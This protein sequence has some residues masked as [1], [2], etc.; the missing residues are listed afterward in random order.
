MEE[1][2]IA[3][4][5][6][7]VNP[8]IVLQRVGQSFDEGFL[9]IVDDRENAS[10]ATGNMQYVRVHIDKLNH[11]LVEE[12]RRRRLVQNE[13]SE[14]Q[15]WCLVEAATA[16]LYMAYLASAVSGARPG[17]FPVTDHLDSLESL[18]G[19]GDTSYG[20][21]VD[22][23]R[24]AA[25]RQAL[26][27]PSG[28]VPPQEIIRFKE[29]YSEQLQRCRT[30]LDGTLADL[31]LIGDRRIQADKGYLVL[32]EIQDD[33]ARLRE[34]MIRRRWPQV[35]MAGVC[36][37]GAA[38]IASAQ[39]FVAGGTP[40]TV[41]LAVGAGLLGLGPATNDAVT[42]FREGRF[43]GNAPLAYAALAARQFG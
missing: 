43:D 13:V 30:Y 8:Q 25:I 9:Q 11:R 4:L 6:D 34:S 17:T 40:L 22:Q 14:R 42:R 32:Q 7:L 38:T 15:S 28:H 21:R 10:L 23:L 41:G 12:L 29:E 36:G 33:V 35:S 20:L 18:G 19:T 27:V 39:A 2:R 24:Y 26:P 3:G 31:A 37:V 1:L 5:L 16:S